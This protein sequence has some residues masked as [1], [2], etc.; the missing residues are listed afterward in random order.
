LSECQTAW[1]QKRLFGV[2]FISKSFVYADLCSDYKY[3]ER[4]NQLILL[5]Q[6]DYMY[7]IVLM[8][9]L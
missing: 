8:K 2:S 7:D 9:D 4:F 1:I 5:Q 6:L 3:N